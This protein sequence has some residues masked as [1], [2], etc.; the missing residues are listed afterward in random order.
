MEELKK[1]ISECFSFLNPEQVDK[2]TSSLVGFCSKNNIANL[3]VIGSGESSITFEYNNEI[4]KLTFMEYD[5][6]K[7]LKEYGS[8][9]R[10]I[11]Q[12]N[13]EEI[14]ELGYY[15]AKILKTKKLQIVNPEDLS[16]S[17]DLMDMYCH[18][19][20]DGYLWYDTKL[21]NIGKDENGNIYLID[22]GEL[23]Y[24]NDMDD[25]HKKKELDSH[26][27]KKSSYCSFYDKLVYNRDI[28]ANNRNSEKCYTKEEIM[29]DPK[30]F[31][32]K[33]SEG[34]KNLEDLL[35][36]CYT[37]DISTLACCA[38]HENSVNLRPY[39]NIVFNVQPE[40]YEMFALLLETMS[41]NQLSDILKLELRNP[42]GQQILFDIGLEDL[43]YRDEF[44]K[45]IKTL[46]EKGLIYN[47]ENA[48]SKIFKLYETLSNKN[49]NENSINLSLKNE[50]I[51]LEVVGVEYIEDINEYSITQKDTSYE[52]NNLLQ[53]L[54]SLENLQDLDISS[55]TNSYVL[56]LDD[57]NNIYNMNFMQNNINVK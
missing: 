6:H 22:Y 5:N 41:K 51:S 35:L 27:L 42:T 13:A 39:A 24:I 31:A 2:I 14:I 15:N 46:L 45:N 38:G 29:Q 1:Y 44:F 48:Y 16:A 9:S 28:E 40:Q 36:F 8:H 49:N 32:Q 4:I 50:N 55:I 20:D 43:K 47:S 25:Y 21:E 30:Y 52:K 57:I 18:L 54:S 3:K 10:Y 53:Y 37:N 23:I 34:N 26:Y 56:S 12:P 11:L 19:R 33:F 17:S 7:S